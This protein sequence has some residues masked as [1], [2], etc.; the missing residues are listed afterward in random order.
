MFNSGEN[1]RILVP[2]SGL[3][4]DIN[5]NFNIV[6]KVKNYPVFYGTAPNGYQNY[7]LTFDSFGDEL[8][9]GNLNI[10][11]NTGKLKILKVDSETNEKIKRSKI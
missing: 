8:A 5:G 2:K 6:G 9:S 4:N 7:T 11:C 1:F 3:I 10:S